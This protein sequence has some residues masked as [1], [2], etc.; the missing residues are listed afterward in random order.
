MNPS[1][2]ASSS[3]AKVQNLF[4]S[5]DITSPPRSHGDLLGVGQSPLPPSSPHPQRP[6]PSLT[7]CPL[8]PRLIQTIVTLTLRVEDIYFIP[9]VSLRHRV[10]KRALSRRHA[11]S[12]LGNSK[13]PQLQHFPKFSHPFHKSWHWKS[14]RRTMSGSPTGGSRSKGKREEQVAG[15]AP[16]PDRSLGAVSGR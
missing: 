2:L 3:P 16:F 13:N 4:D 1:I 5:D 6:R 10:R 9:S 12:G 14:L 11:A 15:P 8:P 7:S